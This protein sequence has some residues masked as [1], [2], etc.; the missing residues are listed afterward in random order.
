MF[1]KRAKYSYLFLLLVLL[2]STVV[3]GSAL[4]NGDGGPDGSDRPVTVMTRN[5]Y[6]GADLTPIFTAII[7]GGDVSAAVGQVYT[8][9][10]L[11]NIPGR[12]AK[13]AGEISA[14]QADLVGLQEVVAWSGPAGNV[15][16]LPLIMAHL[17]GYQAIAVA[18]G[19]NQ[20]FGPIGLQVRDVIL[21]RTDQPTSQLKLSNIQT[22]H[23]GTVV[24][25]SFGGLTI[26]LPRQ[27]ASVDVK[28]RGKSFRFITTHLESIDSPPFGPVRPAQAAE[29]LGGPANTG[30]PVVLV[31]D[32]NSQIGDAGD[33]AQ[34]IVNAGFSSAASGHT[35]CHD[36][37]LDS[38]SA[39]EK[40]ID[41]IFYRGDFKVV[42]AGVTGGPGSF[43]GFWPSD[44]GGVVATLLLPEDQ[45]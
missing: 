10:M 23:Y 8:E 38:G 40:Q 13:M 42:S 19:F 33:A 4:A 34:M 45:D 17:P 44:H 37:L 29:L 9:A 27:W 6:L 12:A 1:K 26:S 2:L 43:S 5:L 32:F 7:Y 35:C 30:L 21:A 25:F 22:G 24:S 18:S 31:G 15:D 11:S 36:N 28:I 39:F 41:F 3:A 14:A 16:F 20:S